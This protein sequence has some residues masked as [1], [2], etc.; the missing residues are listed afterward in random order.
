MF[1]L[2]IALMILGLLRLAILNAVNIGAVLAHARDRSIP[3]KTV[4]QDTARWLL[5]VSKAR[6][7][8][9]F[10]GTSFVFHIT[11]IITPI[12]L[13]AHILLWERG[14]GL[15][16]PSIPQVAADYMTLA[17]IAGAA[18]L[19]IKRVSARA[20]RALSS[21][22]DYLIPLLIIIPFASGYL[23]MHP[24]V[25]PFGYN[26]TMLVHVLSGNL[27]LILLPF[28]KLSHAVLFPTTQLMSEVAW[29][30][31]PGSGHEIAVTL[32]KEGKPI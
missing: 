26:G 1:R 8:A 19:F 12:F 29:H 5:P 10:A 7:Q 16:W 32:G 27:I 9:F 24:S 15:S 13:G 23:A 17:A 3:W 22:Q 4:I 28:S 25:N 2:S 18:V 31:A 21:T 14:I 30:L 20:T 6:T 11:A